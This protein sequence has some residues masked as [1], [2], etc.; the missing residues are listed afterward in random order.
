MVLLY[1]GCAWTVGIILAAVFEPPLRLLATAMLLALIGLVLRRHHAQHRLLFLCGLCVVLG[2]GRYVVALPQFDEHHVATYID[3]A[4]VILEGI[5][6]NDP[7]V[8][9]RSTNLRV[10]ARRLQR[11]GIWHEV[12]GLVLVQVSRYPGWEYGDVVQVFGGLEMPPVFENFS[13]KDYLARKGVHTMM[14][15]PRIEHMGN[16]EGHPVLVAIYAVKDHAKQVVSSIFPEPEASLLSGILLGY[17]RGIPEK[18]REAFSRTNTSHVI[19]ISGFNLALMAGIFSTLFSRFLSPRR[20]TIAVIVCIVLYTILVGANAAVVR[21][22]LMGSMYVIA[23]HNRRQGHALTSLAFAAVLMTLQNPHAL[24]DVG[25]Q[26]SFAATLGLILLVPPMESTFQQGLSHFISRERAQSAINMLSDVLIVTLA[27]QIATIPIMVYYFRQI[28]I[29]G[30]LSNIAVLPAQPPLLILAGLATLVGMIALPLGQL[31]A[32]AAIPF[33][34][35]TIRVVEWMATWPSAF[36]TLESVSQVWLWGYYGIVA[37]LLAYSHQSPATRLSFWQG[38]RDRFSTKLA[39][40]SLTLVAAVSWMGVTALPDGRLHV[41]FFDVGQGDGIF[42][43]TPTGKQVIVDGGPS[44]AAMADAVG[45]WMPFWDRTIDL[46]IMTHADEDHV[47]GLIPILERYSVTVAVE[48]GYPHVSAPYF[49]W[50]DLLRSRQIETVIAR[51]GMTVDLGD[52]VWMEVLNPP[53]PLHQD[54]EADVNNNS[55]VIRLTYGESSFLFTGDIETEVENWL[56]SEKWLNAQVLKIAHH[57][58]DSSTGRRFVEAVQPW[59]AIISAGRDNRFGHPKEEV[60]ERII[61]R[62]IPVYRTDQHGEIEI[63]SDGRRIWVQTE[64]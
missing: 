57:G 62:Y 54:T 19:A 39:L 27:A 38:V 53:H 3:T 55:V 56:V 60:V 12:E 36:I 30:L 5:I 42:I 58:S 16:N 37:G 22:A 48:P 13:Y 59:V 43:S 17:E 15:R 9:D 20:A 11:D 34:Y 26:L 50:R 4:D 46:V 21:A 51:A 2:A 40:G 6:S 32:W 24:W 28:S 47:G 35:Y 10:A 29:V 23:K 1:L 8:R 61:E 25:F 45:R 49:R 63:V 44:P 41:V 31:L 33:P 14:R 64:R 18:V 52:G 7:D